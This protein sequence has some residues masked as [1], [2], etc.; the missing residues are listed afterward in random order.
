VWL[1]HLLSGDLARW[2]VYFASSV[3]NGGLAQLARAPA[4]HAGG[5][6]FDSDI[7]HNCRE[8]E[9]LLYL[10]SDFVFR[11]DKSIVSNFIIRNY[12]PLG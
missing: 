6:R 10:T 1:E 8:L 4:L 11:N 9:L 2:F 7:L 12:I 3:L 5:H